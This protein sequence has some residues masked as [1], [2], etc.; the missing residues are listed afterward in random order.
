MTNVGAIAGLTNVG[1]AVWRSGGLSGS[2]DPWTEQQQHLQRQHY[3]VT[4]AGNTIA[5][6]VAVLPPSYPTSDKG[7]VAVPWETICRTSPV[8]ADFHQNTLMLLYHGEV[9]PQALGAGG[10]ANIRR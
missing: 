7:I 3:W 5:L 1:P 10:P 8:G 9:C 2:H 6:K 4:A